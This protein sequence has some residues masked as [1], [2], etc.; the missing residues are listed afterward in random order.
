MSLWWARQ[1][2]AR[3]KGLLYMPLLEAEF[4]WQS[5]QTHQV[6]RSG[7]TLTHA[8]FLTTTASQGQTIRAAG[9][10][11]DCARLPPQGRT[12][13]DDDEWWLNLYVMLSRA[14]RMSDMMLLR[15]PPRDLL[16][17][18]PPR[19][20]LK[21]LTELQAKIARSTRAAEALAQRLGFVLPPA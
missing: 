19:S 16:E 17:R 2:R 5:S 18:G 1:Q 9:V 20:V 12:G 14:T 15:P 10:T 8:Y 7:F 4:S 21:A 13:K 3:A 11:I 6:K